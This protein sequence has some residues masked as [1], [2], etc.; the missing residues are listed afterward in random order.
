MADIYQNTRRHIPKESS[1][2]SH[3]R[4]HLKSHVSIVVSSDIH[5]ILF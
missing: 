2:Q 4:E 5:Q 3:H 1:F